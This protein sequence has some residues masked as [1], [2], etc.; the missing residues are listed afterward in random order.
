MLGLTRRA[1]ALIVYRRPRTF[2]IVAIPDEIVSK[3]RVAGT[4]PTATDVQR[5]LGK[6]SGW[7]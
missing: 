1:E 3:Q 7:L 6:S 5:L 4:S 2:T